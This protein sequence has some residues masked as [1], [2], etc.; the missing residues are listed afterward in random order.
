MSARTKHIFIKSVQTIPSVFDW[1]KI[2]VIFHSLLC[3][4]CN[5]WQTSSYLFCAYRDFCFPDPSGIQCVSQ[6]YTIKDHPVERLCIHTC[7]HSHE[8]KA[9]GHNG[10]AGAW[11]LAHAHT[12]SYIFNVCHEWIMRLPY[13]SW[14]VHSIF[15]LSL[16]FPLPLPFHFSF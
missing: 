6:L 12:I 4:M 11:A 15:F 13:Y 16:F 14:V 2:W 7:F 9:S 1:I 5:C 3:A 10:S 8:L